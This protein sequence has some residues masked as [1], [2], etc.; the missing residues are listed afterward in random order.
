MAKLLDDAWQLLTDGMITHPGY[1]GTI[2]LPH[3]VAATA[4][5]RRSFTPEAWS[6]LPFWHRLFGAYFCHGY[7]GSCLRDLLLSR[8]PSL[9]A[10]PTVPAYFLAGWLLTYYSPCDIVYRIVEQPRHP[11]RLALIFGETVDAATTIFGAFETTKK[12]QPQAPL[13][14]YAIAMLV[15]MGGSMFRYFERR[16]RGMQVKAEWTHPTGGV[17]SSATY[18]AIYVLVRRRYGTQF[19]R[20]WV[21]LMV[22]AINLWAELS[23][24]SDFNP[25]AWLC[26]A[27]LSG[28]ERARLALRL[29]PPAA[30]TPALVDSA[31]KKVCAGAVAPASGTC[32]HS[33]L[34]HGHGVHAHATYCSRCTP[35]LPGTTPRV[36]SHGTLAHAAQQR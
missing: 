6:T 13:A 16:G 34:N 12:L 25:A 23:G 28:C 24:R 31:D 4:S 1:P 10:H 14:P 26:D 7:G 21:T 35:H 27:L 22:C 17:Q 33:H 15:S 32:Q 36:A 5:F 18:L 9:T 30:S 3:A 8:P 20:L 11:L 19:A 2:Q 29:G